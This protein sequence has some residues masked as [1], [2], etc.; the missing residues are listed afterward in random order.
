[1]SQIELAPAYLCPFSGHCHSNTD[2]S[3]KVPVMVNP[4]GTKQGL[5][6]AVQSDTALE[7]L[8]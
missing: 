1:M 4:R 3:R 8:T 7:L 6:L 2:T 5:M